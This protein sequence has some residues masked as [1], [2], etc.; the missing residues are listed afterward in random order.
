M[1]GAGIFSGLTT[2]LYPLSVIKTRMMALEGAPPGLK[3]AIYTAREVL[4]HDG[5]KGLYKGFGTVVFGIIPARMIYLSTLESS[6]SFMH[7]GLERWYPDLSETVRNTYASFVAGATASL[8]GQLVIVPVD[9]VSQRLM[10]T[11]GPRGISYAADAMPSA[12]AQSSRGGSH[13]RPNG[14]QLTRYILK[15]EGIRGLYRGMGASIVTFVP[16]SAIWWTAYGFWKDSLFYHIDRFRS[17]TTAD[18]AVMDRS[19]G[20]ILTVQA[21]SGLL[22]G[23]TSAGLTNPLDVV[24]TRL[25]TA[26]R[27]KSYSRDGADVASNS[28]RTSW[29]GTVSNLFRSEGVRGFYRGVVPRMMNT[30]VWG[31]AM[32]TTYEFLKRLCALPEEASL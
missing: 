24:K 11:G 5:I 12:Q 8:A 21:I 15:R 27:E 22:T 6:K 7:A 20:E 1:L 19:E 30:A 29:G 26:Q 23:C 3:G 2:A 32:V 25:Q 28:A 18:D 10:I 9:V 14:L 31:T 13:N 17:S 16:T 4:S